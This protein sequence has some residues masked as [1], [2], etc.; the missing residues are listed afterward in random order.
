MSSTLNELN[1]GIN[2]L[3]KQTASLSDSLTQ[4]TKTLALILTN[5]KKMTKAMR[6]HKVQNFNL[7]ESFF[8]KIIYQIPI[9]LFDETEVQTITKSSDTNSVVSMNTVN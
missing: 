1:Q 9:V 4:Q 2:Q 5:Q 8:F 3:R 6:T 7:N